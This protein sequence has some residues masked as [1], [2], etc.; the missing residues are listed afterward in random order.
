MKSMCQSL[1]DPFCAQSLGHVRLF[2]TTM[3][4]SCLWDSL[5]KNTGVDFHFLL[6]EI[7]L[8]QGLSQHLLHLL[9]LQEDSLPL[10]QLGS[11]K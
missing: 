11:P 3:D 2:A 6:Q 7:F 1:N 5:G 10:F 8:T 9:H 4:Y